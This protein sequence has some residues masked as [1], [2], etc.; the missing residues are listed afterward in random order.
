M[1]PRLIRCDSVEAQ[2]PCAMCD[3]SIIIATCGPVERLLR[4]LDSVVRA[5]HLAPG[6]HRVVVVDNKPS[7]QADSQMRDFAGRPDISVDFMTSRPYCKSAALNMGIAAASTEWL[8]FTDDDAIVD[9]E[10]LARAG[11]YASRGGCCVFGGRVRVGDADGTLPRWA[12]G[13][14]G[15]DIPMLGAAL[16][17]YKPRDRSGLLME[18]DPVPLGANFFVRKDV[19]ARHGGYDEGLWDACGRYALGAEDA[20]MGLRLRRGKEPIGYCHEAVVRH[21]VFVERLR[22]S[23]LMRKAFAYGWRE[24]VLFPDARPVID[25]YTLRQ[26]VGMSGRLAGRG[27]RLDKAGC[28]AVLLDMACLAGEAAGR[29]SGGRR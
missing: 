27:L 23:F 21:P 22:L 28:I 5:A 13:V 29:R 10:W 15:G 24:H 4:A 25:G 9:D 7:R 18:T 3:F 8:A 6:R 16:V 17:H 19:F 2:C 11:D 1:V 20:E 12:R 14:K 26:A